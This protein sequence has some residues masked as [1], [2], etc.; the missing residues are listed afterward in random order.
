MVNIRIAMSAES[1]FGRQWPVACVN[2]ELADVADEQ[3]MRPLDR[4]SS[5]SVEAD[6]SK[7]GKHNFLGLGKFQHIKIARKINSLTRTMY[8][9]VYL[10]VRVPD[11]GVVVNC[12]WVGHQ[13]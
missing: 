4:K 8:G 3:Y 11:L 9:I 13:E 5:K 7:L 12:R 6:I 1:V 2:G 10:V